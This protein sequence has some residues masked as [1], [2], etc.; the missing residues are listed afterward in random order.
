LPLKQEF[1][2][3]KIT[4]TSAKKPTNLASKLLINR[5][6]EPEMKSTVS[7]MSKTKQMR[8]PN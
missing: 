4:T 5:G 7:V 8:I 1:P 2:V 6:E 3:S